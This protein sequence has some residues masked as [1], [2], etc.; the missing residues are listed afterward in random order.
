MTPLETDD[1]L[2]AVRA[3]LLADVAE[4][5][6]AN[7]VLWLLGDADPDE[8]IKANAARCQGVSLLIYDQGG[9]SQQDEDVILSTAAVELYV[10]PMK[11][12]RKVDANRRTPAAIRNDIMQK[13]HRSPTLRNLS[14]NYD[15]RVR[16]YQALSDPEFVAYRIT[17]SHSIFLQD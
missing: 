8:S 3:A 11:H 5:L 14:P 17:I 1:F 2:T 6:D 10:S 4:C 12:G 9:T 7:T 15:C 13:L 16:G